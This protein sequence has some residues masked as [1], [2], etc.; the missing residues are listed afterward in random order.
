MEKFSVKL[1]AGVPVP[2]PAGPPGPTGPQGPPPPYTAILNY[3]ADT[4][5]T[6]AADPGTGLLRWNSDTVETVTELYVDRLAADS[7]INT[8]VSAAWLMANPTQLLIHQSD[9]AMNNQTWDVTGPIEDRTDWLVVPVRLVSAKG[10]W[11]RAK[12]PDRTALLVFLI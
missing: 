3:R 6:A 5:S 12:P 10:A 9:L 2:G 4:T 8:D 7:V 1:A 11:E